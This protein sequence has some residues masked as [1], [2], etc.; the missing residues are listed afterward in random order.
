M[1]QVLVQAL[2][3]IGLWLSLA[4]AASAHRPNESYLYFQVSEARLTGRLEM[5]LA[6]LGRVLPLDADGD[7]RVSEA[8]ARAEAAALHALLAGA[9]AIEAGGETV[10]I[11]PGTLGFLRTG[12]ATYAQIG[13][14][15]PG[16]AP[17]PERIRLSYAPPFGAL[18]PGHSGH[19]L[20]ESN[21]RTGVVANESLISVSFLPGDTTRDL[22]LAGTPPARVFGDF[23]LFGV[24]HVWLG[25]EHLL[26]LA[27]LILPSVMVFRD[28]RWQAGAPPGPVAVGLGL[29]VALMIGAQAAGMAALAAGAPALSDGAVEWLV[30][31]GVVLLAGAGF[32]PALLRW[33]GAV[34]AGTGLAHGLGA[35]GIMA[36]VGGEPVRAAIAISG[37]GLGQAGAMLALIALALPV[38]VALRDWR[39]YAVLSMRLGAAGLIALAA[40]WAIERSFDLLGPVR[41]GLGG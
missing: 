7:G 9:V 23:A 3:V 11:S 37:F 32:V 40:L 18:P 15:L 5:T 39:L 12:E 22:G 35:A 14:G 6:D 10:A 24:W 4:G 20:I 34:V 1:V 13:F 8:E 33:R 38:M 17:V 2:V 27:A 41:A 29:L 28:G 25:I 19:A 31:G 16:L 21:T 30:A 36:S 26:F